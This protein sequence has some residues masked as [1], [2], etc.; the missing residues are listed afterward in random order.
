PP[1]GPF[2]G[3]SLGGG[4]FFRVPGTLRGGALRRFVLI[5]VALRLGTTRQNRR[6]GQGGD[7][8]PGGDARSGRP[9]RS[10]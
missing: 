3:R 6:E 4:P 7:E 1:R 8:D 2:A 10:G 9:A 5:A